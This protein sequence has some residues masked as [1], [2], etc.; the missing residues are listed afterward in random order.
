MQYD[1]PPIF[2]SIVL[3]AK[4]RCNVA[5]LT[6]F[7][8]DKIP[9]NLNFKNL[10]IRSVEHH[11]EKVHA[12]VQSPNMYHGVQ[13]NVHFVLYK[14]FLFEVGEPIVITCYPCVSFK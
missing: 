5:F 4:N 9:K 13:I 7:C 12:N 6:V 2:K 11:T 14:I 1:F 3:Y 10:A 8:I